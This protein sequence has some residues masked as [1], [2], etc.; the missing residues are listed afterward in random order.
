MTLCLCVCVFRIVLELSV[1]LTTPGQSTRE[2]NKALLLHFLYL[3]S[4][5]SAICLQFN[6]FFFLSEAELLLIFL[7]TLIDVFYNV[8]YYSC[9]FFLKQN[10]IANRTTLAFCFSHFRVYTQ[11][12]DRDTSEPT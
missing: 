4:L 2:R 9:N 11:G 10:L 3:S 7:F 1:L 8:H 5:L 12:Q 6:H